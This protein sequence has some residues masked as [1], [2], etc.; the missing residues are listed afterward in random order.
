[1]A[2][3]QGEMKE[4]AQGLRWSETL[5]KVR[6]AYLLVTK[7][8]SHTHLSLR[9]PFLWLQYW[10][11]TI[12]NHRTTIFFFPILSFSSVTG[13]ATS[14]C[15]IKLLNRFSS[16]VKDILQ[17]NVCVNLCGLMLTIIKIDSV[18]LKLLQYVG[19]RG[20]VVVKALCCKP[21]GRAF[22]SRWSGFFKLT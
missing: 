8:W 16:C 4:I 2:F 14:P 6:C 13:P 20:N 19:P 12:D 15:F 7:S 5:A 11:W 21:E 1:M 18:F 17:K 3:F 10:S 22:K 9:C